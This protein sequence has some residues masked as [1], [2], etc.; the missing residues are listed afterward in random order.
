MIIFEFTLAQ[1]F[2]G[3]VFGTCLSKF[4]IMAVTRCIFITDGFSVW[5]VTS[6][7]SLW[8]CQGIETGLSY[9]TLLTVVYHGDFLLL[10]HGIR[11][12]KFN[13]F[14]LILKL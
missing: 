5:L 9:I 4:K 14:K 12:V 1:V 11:M 3:L 2:K 10:N 7:W 8:L 13:F 6:L